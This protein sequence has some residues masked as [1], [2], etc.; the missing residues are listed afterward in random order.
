MFTA[1]SNTESPLA[2]N[3]PSPVSVETSSERTSQV[4]I[5]GRDKLNLSSNDHGTDSK[6]LRSEK[7]SW[8]KR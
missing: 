4:V 3:Y 2:G 8:T 7:N 6:Y 5:Q 1:T